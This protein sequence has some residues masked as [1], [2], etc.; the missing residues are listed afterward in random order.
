MTSHCETHS[1]FTVKS[2]HFTH[3]LL[4]G[5]CEVNGETVYE[6]NITLILL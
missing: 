1:E 6:Y 5:V 4:E 2:L 3:T